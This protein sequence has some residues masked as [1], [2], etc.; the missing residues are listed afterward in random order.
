M[1]AI[2]TDSHFSPDLERYPE[3]A[4]AAPARML[5]FPSR[6]AAA[7]G[8]ETLAPD[9]ALRVLAVVAAVLLVLVVAVGTAALGRVLDGQRGIA[10]SAPAAEVSSPH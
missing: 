3:I 4:D 2:T 5:P 1:V 7:A 10:A 6:H 8:G 9:A